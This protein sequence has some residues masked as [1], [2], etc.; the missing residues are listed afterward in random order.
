[1]SDDNN[2]QNK[3]KNEWQERELGALW[4]REGKSGK[5]FYGKFGDQACVIF[6]NKHKTSD[7]HPDFIVYKSEDKK[8]FTQEKEKSEETVSTAENKDDDLF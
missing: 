4:V 3:E 5:Y 7:K 2:N 8:S 1:M 6:R